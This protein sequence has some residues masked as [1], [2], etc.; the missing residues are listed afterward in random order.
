MLR[1]LAALCGLTALCGYFEQIDWAAV[2]GFAV[3]AAA[4]CLADA[5]TGF[6]V[7][8]KSAPT[9]T[10]TAV[11]LAFGVAAVGSRW[12]NQGPGS[13]HLGRNI[14]VVGLLMIRSSCRS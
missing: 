11:P 8:G 13:F 10:T 5:T 7:V 4:L 3:S 1:I 6:T 9:C 14:W 2:R 12:R